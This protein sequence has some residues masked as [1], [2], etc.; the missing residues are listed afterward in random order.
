MR[1][2]SSFECRIIQNSICCPS[3][4]SHSVRSFSVLSLFHRGKKNEGTYSSKVLCSFDR[5]YRLRTPVIIS[6]TRS[7][8]PPISRVFPFAWSN[9]Y[10]FVRIEKSPTCKKEFIGND[11]GVGRRPR[12]RHRNREYIQWKK[13]FS[14][15]KG[16][17]YFGI[18]KT[19]SNR[20]LNSFKEVKFW[21]TPS[22]TSGSF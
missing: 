21:N 5:Y 3:A 14:I 9:N 6:T 10:Q 20:R 18:D 2:H 8:G 16:M 11:F 12:R 1:P 7:V 15:S 19:G 13:P 22:T 17:I 4:T